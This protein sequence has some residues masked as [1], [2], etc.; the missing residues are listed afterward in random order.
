MN[1][2]FGVL[3]WGHNQGQSKTRLVDIVSSDQ[4]TVNQRNYNFVL[5]RN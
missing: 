1:V 2:C 5:T 3:S 4:L